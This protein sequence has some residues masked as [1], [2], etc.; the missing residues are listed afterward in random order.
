M[1]DFSEQ[2]VSRRPLGLTAHL[3]NFVEAGATRKA[4]IAVIVVNAIVIGLETSPTAMAAAGNLLRAIDTLALAIFAPRSS[5][6][7]RGAW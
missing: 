6:N 4:I 2:A 1:T 7:S 3:R 5:A